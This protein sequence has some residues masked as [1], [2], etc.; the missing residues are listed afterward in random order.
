L[1]DIQFVYFDIDDTLLDHKTAQEHALVDVYNRFQDQFGDIDLS[2]VQQI[3][4]THNVALWKQYALGE[5]DRPFLQ[6]QR[7]LRLVQELD[8]HSAPHQEIGSYYMKQ[9]AEHWTYCEGAY[10]TFTHI[11]DQYP[12]GVLTNGFTEV[13][14]AKLARFNELR[15][16][17]AATVISEEVGYM[18]PH[19]ELFKHASA[20]AETAPQHI[21]YIGDSYTSDIE[22]GL[23]A[24]W[25]VIWY[26][27]QATNIPNGVDHITTLSELKDRL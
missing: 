7:F 4:H 5:I 1:K 23:N 9:Y 27:P 11:A 17:L 10:E 8:I 26:K 14:H 6:E 16:R 20:K 18:K 3:Y 13:Q 24:G 12:V 19:P 25:N 15:D 22:G 21:L 2:T